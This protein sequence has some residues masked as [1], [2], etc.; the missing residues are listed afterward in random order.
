MR[1][2]SWWV[3]V[4]LVA[5]TGCGAR[6]EVS[7][8]PKSLDGATIASRA[9]T[10]LEKENPQL[11]HGH[12]TCADVKYKVGATTR[13]LR[14]VV[15]DDGRLVR[16]G[17]TVTIDKV[18]GG[19]HFKIKVDDEATSSASPE[20]RSSPTSRSSTPPSTAG[21]RRPAAARRT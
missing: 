10:Q 5:L 2:R 4:L 16:I 15:L 19:G 3:P 18:T 11:T 17:A 21:R 6:V 20:H 1:R 12:L 8:K 13:C 7:S 9:N 14:T